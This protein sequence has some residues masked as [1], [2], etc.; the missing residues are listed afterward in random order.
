MEKRTLKYFLDNKNFSKISQKKEKGSKNKLT[1]VDD[2]IVFNSVDPQDLEDEIVTSY[3]YMSKKGNRKRWNDE[4]THL[5]YKALECCGC[6][7]SLMNTL[8]PNRSRS[9]L[10]QKY[11][12]EIKIN[13]LKIEMTL[14]NYKKFNLDKFNELKGEIESLYKID[15]QSTTS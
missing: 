14:E 8:F 11:K 12:K 1:I 6:D 9:N 10:K 5:F 13:L 3:T 15:T 7:F 4:D 2:Q